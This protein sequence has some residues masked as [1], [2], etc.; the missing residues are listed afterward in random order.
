MSSGMQELTNKTPFCGGQCEE[1]CWRDMFRV[2]LHFGF[3]RGPG[4]DRHKLVLLENK[5]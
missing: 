4:P 2:G 1:T 5:S 3:S